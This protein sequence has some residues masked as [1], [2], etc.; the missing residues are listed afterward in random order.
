MHFRSPFFFFNDTATTEIYTL[1]LHDA[2]PIFAAERKA[3]PGVATHQ[4]LGRPLGARRAVTGRALVRVNRGTLRRGSAA[5]WQPGSVRHHVDVPRRG[6]RGRGRLPEAVPCSIFP[7]TRATYHESE[8]EPRDRPTH[9]STLQS[10][11]D[12]AVT[13]HAP[14]ADV[15]EVI[16]G[17]EPTGG[18]QLLEGRRCGAGL[19]D[20]TAPERC[21]P[22]I[23]LPQVLEPRVALGEHRLLQLGGL[24]PFP[25]VGADVHPGNPAPTAPRDS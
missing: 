1:S 23:P 2:L 24:P 17:A 9:S 21:F 14:R 15:I 3:L 18:A 4:A 7:A 6:V 8:H 20:R 13:L 12:G 19:V 16:R 22:A 25:P 10:E 5:G 11:H